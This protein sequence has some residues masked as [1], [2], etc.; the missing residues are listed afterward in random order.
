MGRAI[1]ILIIL[2]IAAGCAGPET[3]PQANRPLD[4]S[5]GLHASAE[6][7][8]QGVDRPEFSPRIVE[9]D[10]SPWICYPV[11]LQVGNQH[12]TLL[13]FDPSILKIQKNTESQDVWV[14]LAA[15]ARNR[16]Y[17]M[18]R[19]DGQK[20][21]GYQIADTEHGGNESIISFEDL[22]DRFGRQM[23][24]LQPDKI[25]LEDDAYDILQRNLK[26]VPSRFVRIPG[27]SYSHPHI[28]ADIHVYGPKPAT[29]PSTQP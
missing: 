18:F 13:G 1:P 28:Y 24:P 3:D 7:S 22:E 6:V 10:A 8:L 12:V 4:P 21:Y 9:V 14:M 27:D 16:T 15:Y 26:K 25:Y 20:I 29:V 19:Y 2:F 5:A 17:L 11:V 23:I